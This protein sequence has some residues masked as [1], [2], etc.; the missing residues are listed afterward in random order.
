V[1][2]SKIFLV[3]AVITLSLG[4]YGCYSPWANSDINVNFAQE[5]LYN[6]II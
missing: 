5:S 4:V 6:T 1:K 2:K 3:I